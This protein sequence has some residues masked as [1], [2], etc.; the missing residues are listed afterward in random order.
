MA[1]WKRLYTSGDIFKLDQ[2]HDSYVLEHLVTTMGLKTKS[3]SG[4]GRA[5]SHPFINGPLG[6]YMDHM[7]G[8]RKQRGRS[9]VT[10]LRVQRS[11]PYWAPNQPRTT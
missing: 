9:P 3:L 1:E 8:P 4:T 2:W 10:D 7:K 6:G 5:T 11:E